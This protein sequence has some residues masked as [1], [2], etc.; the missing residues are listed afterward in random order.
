[1]SDTIKTG[2]KIS[3]EYTGRIKSGEVFDTSRGR[4]SLSFEVGAGQMIKGFDNAVFDRGL[5][6]KRP[7]RSL[8]KKLTVIKRTI[9]LLP[10]P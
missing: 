4:E 7:S 8:L 10:C 9:F 2:N 6:T 5:V 1:M 3:V